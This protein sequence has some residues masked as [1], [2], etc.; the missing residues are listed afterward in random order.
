MPNQAPSTDSW[1]RLP[2]RYWLA[3]VP[4]VLAIT[5]FLANPTKK[6]VNPVLKSSKVVVRCSISF[7][8]T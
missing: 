8:T 5:T 7:S 1:D 6:R 2:S 3:S 4:A